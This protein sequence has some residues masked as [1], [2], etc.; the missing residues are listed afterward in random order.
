MDFNGS[1]DSSITKKAPRRR[2]PSYPSNTIESCVAFVSRIDKEFTSAVYTPKGAISEALET[3]GGGFFQ[4]LSSCVQYGLLDIKSGDGYKPTSLHKKI[5]R[6]IPGENPNDGLIE[7]LNNPELYK[8]LI[9]DFR[10]KDLPSENGL[11]NILDRLYEIKGNASF[12]ASKIFL[13]NITALGLIVD[14]K[15]KLDSY[16]P[17]EPIEE[18]KSQEVDKENTPLLIPS[19]IK[20]DKKEEQKT[21]EYRTL[22]IFLSTSSKREAKL[23]LPIDFSNDELKKIIKVIS[24]YLD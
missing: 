3:S 20:P 21:E 7:C 19:T 18:E 24:S 16:I 23:I 15:L 22:P 11:A 6:P 1:P 12:I 10:D 9:S 13:K 14:N 8:K 17:F 4:Q 5:T 2:S